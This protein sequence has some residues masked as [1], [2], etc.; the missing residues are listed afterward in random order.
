MPRYFIYTYAIASLIAI[1]LILF[2]LSPYILSFQPENSGIYILTLSYAFFLSIA[3]MF[4]LLLP[5]FRK[6][7][8]A[9]LG[10]RLIIMQVAI[11]LPFLM[12][13]TFV[14]VILLQGH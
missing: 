4:T 6:E 9:V 2:G 8:I 3:L 11:T 12:W 1:A 10:K 13:G 5:Q 14:L 7:L